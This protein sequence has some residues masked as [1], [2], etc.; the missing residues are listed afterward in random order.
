MLQLSVSTCDGVSR[1]SQILSQFGFHL[2]C[3]LKWHRIQ[4]LVQLRHQSHT[5]FSDYPSGFVA[6][7]VIFEPVIDREPCHADIDTRLQRISVGIDAHNGRMFC[8]SVFQ[9]NYIY[10]VVKRLFQVAVNF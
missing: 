5:I 4:V 1:R 7:F 6:V 10:V 8:N 2:D 9:Q 3:G